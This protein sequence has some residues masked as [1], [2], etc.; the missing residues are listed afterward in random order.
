MQ[1]NKIKMK[2]GRLCSYNPLDIQGVYIDDI[3]RDVAE[4][5]DYIAKTGNRIYIEGKNDAY[6]I[7][8]LAL[9]GRKYLR[10]LPNE[11]FVDKL[12]DLPRE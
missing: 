1:V 7:N 4:V 2:Q 11:S 3:Y 9:N 5:Y 10:S 6:L 12:F 8:V